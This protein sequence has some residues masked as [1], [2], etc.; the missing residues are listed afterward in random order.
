M[1][2]GLGSGRLDWHSQMDAKQGAT[3]IKDLI[4]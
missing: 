3:T 1:P 4:E 2:K